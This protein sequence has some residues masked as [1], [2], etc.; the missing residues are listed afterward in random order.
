MAILI[1]ELEATQATQYQRTW[2]PF[3][4]GIGR[5]YVL[6]GGEIP[7][8][9]GKR[10]VLRVHYTDIPID[11]VQEGFIAAF[12]LRVEQGRLGPQSQVVGSGAR[13][14]PKIR[15]I[16]LPGTPGLPEF[17][18]RTS[19]NV[20][21]P[22]MRAG[23][24]A[25]SV[26]VISYAASGAI[27]LI[28]EVPINLE[29]H[30]RRLIRVRLVRI[31]HVQSAFNQLPFD[32]QAPTV[33]DFWRAAELAQRML[34][35]PEP[36]FVVVGDSEVG[37]DGSFE[38]I[39]DRAHDTTWP[40]YAQNSGT[41]GHLPS[42]MDRIITS[43]ARPADVV[44]VGLFHRVSGIHPI[45]AHRGHWLITDD[46]GAQLAHEIAHLHGFP[47][48]APCGN[49]G[50]LDPN[51]PDMNAVYPHDY[52]YAV[53]PP[54]SIGPRGFDTV[55]MRGFDP[56][57]TYD[58]MTECDPRWISGYTHQKVF[59]ALTPLP[60]EEPATSTLGDPRS[61]SF[62]RVSFLESHGDW[63]EVALPSLPRPFP[64]LPEPPSPDASV[65][66]FDSQEQILG[67]FPAVATPEEAE[68][69]PYRRLDADVAYLDSAAALALVADE[70]TLFEV[71]LAGP[72][73]LQ[74]QF[75]SASELVAG[76][77]VVHWSVKSSCDRPLVGIRTSVNA[78]RT[79]TTVHMA[80][81]ARGSFDLREALS[82]GGD[83]YCVEVVASTG[84][85]TRSETHGPFRVNVRPRALQ[86]LVLTDGDN[87]SFR[88]PVE[89]FAVPDSEPSEIQ[90]A[91]N[92]DGP[93]GAGYRLRAKLSP[94]SHTIE[95]R[96]SRPF[97]TPTYLN[98]DIEPEQ[99]EIPC[100]PGHAGLP[101]G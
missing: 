59:P 99:A 83:A 5:G 49:P 55:A 98:V 36:G 69:E 89:F 78:G 33:A 7:L 56:T 66:V 20:V 53:M 11:S 73:R 45:S 30:E 94:G 50:P 12:A 101:A 32:T 86:A 76:G 75:P 68:G 82:G 19:A 34:P 16:G 31:R 72:P 63:V 88:G 10:T 67:R 54:G 90:W 1:Y 27:N 52:Y 2:I 29:F 92:V 22:P 77:G 93:L 26:L 58:V 17:D 62:V 40:G 4:G 28:E 44:Y 24:H 15:T 81:E 43:E 57:T 47:L 96:S 18:E 64:P 95:V 39:D 3:P 79:W 91:S 41:T 70:R 48:N 42:M 14:W 6:F 51:Y 38:S 65:V 35:L 74:V 100:D 37:Y 61:P 87:G 13:A 60:A 46:K 9:A 8:V 25:L 21:L 23:L 71:K 97:D 85:H 80:G 84:Y